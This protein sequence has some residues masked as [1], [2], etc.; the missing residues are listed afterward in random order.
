MS[1]SDGSGPRWT[2]R[3]R[4]YRQEAAE[5]AGTCQLEDAQSHPLQG[6]ITSV[7]NT[8]STSRSAGDKEGKRGS[9]LKK[10]SSSVV[11]D[12]LSQFASEM[13]NPISRLSISQV[14]GLND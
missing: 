1:N 11:V 10:M 8:V 13:V 9:G 3:R 5:R 4:Q 2:I 14:C 6:V 12:P 7:P